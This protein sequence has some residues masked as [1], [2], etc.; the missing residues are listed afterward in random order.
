MIRYIITIFFILSAI[1]IE[2]MPPHPDLEKKLKEEGP[3]WID[4]KSKAPE[5]FLVSEDKSTPQKAAIL[6]GTSSKIVRIPVL[7]VLYGTPYSASSDI[8]TYF[9]KDRNKFQY[10]LMIVIITL[11]LLFAAKKTKTKLRPAFGLLAIATIAMFASCGTENVE[12]ELDF[13][14]DISLY[15]DMLN[16]TNNFTLSARKYFSDMSKGNLTV[17]FDFYGPVKVSKPWYYYGENTGAPGTDAHPGELVSEAIRL[18]VAKYSSTDFSIYDSNND[19]KVDAIIIIHEG[20]GEE[21][22]GDQ[23]T[24]WSHE[25]DLNSAKVIYNDGYGPIYTDGVY[26]N[27][28]TTVPE[29]NSTRGESTIGVFCHELGHALGLPDLYDTSNQTY[30]V[31]DWSLMG[32]GSWGGTPAGSRPAPL[33]AWERYYL[34]GSAWLTVTE[35]TSSCNDKQIKNIEESKEVFK[36]MLDSTTDQNQYIILEGKKASTSN[37]WYVPGTGILITHIHEGVIKKYLSSNQVNYSSSRIHGI[38]IKE[39]DGSHLWSKTNKG[40]AADLYT[41]GGISNIPK[42]TDNTNY[43]LTTNTT[44]KTISDIQ[45]G[46]TMTFDYNP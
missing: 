16:G 28:Y 14:T 31:G 30:G 17:Y 25:Y 39:A 11:L 5:D 36:I 42:Y 33:L 4:T 13:P 22:G 20:P 23:N 18:M 34:G 12:D 7:F 45:V 19:K 6:Q 2:A 27:T 37:E 44:S 1:N 15:D 29:Y 35:L 26:F 8:Y 9:K 43:T 10:A 41:S 21:F 46:T 38:N 40:N 24:I 32:S 3:T